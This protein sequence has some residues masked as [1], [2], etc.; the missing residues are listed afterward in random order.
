MTEEEQRALAWAVASGF[1]RPGGNER[2]V[3][4]LQQLIEVF[5]IACQEQGLEITVRR[6]MP[7]VEEDKP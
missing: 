2:S 7:P 6:V 4:A 5:D 1:S 3:V